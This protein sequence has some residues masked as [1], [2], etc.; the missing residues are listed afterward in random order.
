MGGG[1]GVKRFFSGLRHLLGLLFLGEDYPC[2]YSE[3]MR[4]RWK[5]WKGVIGPACPGCK[6]L[7]CPFR[8]PEDWSTTHG[9]DDVAI[10]NDPP[11]REE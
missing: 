3:E 5:E 6:D 10:L 1:S 9:A 7:R 2:A 8:R 11:F 4:E